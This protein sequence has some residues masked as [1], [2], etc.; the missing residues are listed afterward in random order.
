MEDCKLSLPVPSS[1]LKNYS[2]KEIYERLSSQLTSYL[3]KVY[4][5]GNI[6]KDL[7]MERKL[8]KGASPYTAT[9]QTRLHCHLMLPS[10]AK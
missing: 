8:L 1:I 2:I 5:P 7:L 10:S 9:T 3:F 4:M 6:Y